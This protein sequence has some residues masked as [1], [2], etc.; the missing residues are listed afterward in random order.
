MKLNLIPQNTI[1]ALFVILLLSTLNAQE[2]RSMAVLDFDAT[3]VSQSDVKTLSNRVNT[4]LSQSNKFTVIER[5]KINQLL[6]E[7]S[8]QLSGVTSNESMVA[9]GEVLGVE[10]MFAGGIGLIGKT[11]TIDIRVIEVETGEV[12]HSAST[13][14]RGEIDD[15][16]LK[17]LPAVLNDLIAGKTSTNKVIVQTQFLTTTTPTPSN[18]S[19]TSQNNTDACFQ[20]KI[21]A[22]D[23]IKGYGW[24]AAG[25]ACGLVGYG[26]SYVV[27]PKGPPTRYL[28]G[29]DAVYVAR[30]TMCY[31]DAAK[32]IQKS[33]ALMGCVAYGAYFAA[34][35]LLASPTP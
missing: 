21:D 32:E 31:K 34:T 18:I 9:M 30:Y 19:S 11:Y 35:T 23:N 20:A 4:M 26:A 28:I 15:L 27:D 5:G 17:G 3:G 14:V 33:K 22:K 10:L 8:F 7:Q 2:K 13:N 12:I 6:S 29:K 25:F 1:K 24:M 16:L